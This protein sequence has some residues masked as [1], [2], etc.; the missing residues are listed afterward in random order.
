MCQNYNI[1]VISFFIVYHLYYVHII[2]NWL[3][4]NIRKIIGALL[5][6]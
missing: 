4:G 5:K 6:F 1:L 3:K 2:R